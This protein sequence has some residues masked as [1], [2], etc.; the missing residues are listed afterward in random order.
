[1]LLLLRHE[2]SMPHRPTP[3]KED[4]KDTPD[5]EQQLEL[6]LLAGHWGC[7]REEGG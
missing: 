3:A 5:R 4:P 1:M 2:S 6:L 7:G